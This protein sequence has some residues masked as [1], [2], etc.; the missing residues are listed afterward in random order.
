MEEINDTLD[1]MGYELTQA[2][3][4]F[5]KFRKGN[6]AAG[7]RLRKS[8]QNL[9]NQSQVIRLAVQAHKTGS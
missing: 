3:E 7:T 2:L 4:E 6:A 9:K 8:M 1:I 5:N